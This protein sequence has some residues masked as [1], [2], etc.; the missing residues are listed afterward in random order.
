VTAPLDGKSVI[1]TD[2]ATGIG[3]DNHGDT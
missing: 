2:T 3:E 1:V